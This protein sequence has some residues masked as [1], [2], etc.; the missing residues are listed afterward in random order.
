MK[1]SLIFSMALGLAFAAC[2]K[3]EVPIYD[4]DKSNFILF[5]NPEESYSVFSFS[6]HPEVEAGAA[7]E[8]AIPIEIMGMTK[9]YDREY[10]VSIVDTM[11][12]AKQGT[13]FT[14]PEKCVF[15]AG[16][17]DDTLF[18]KLYRV[19]DLKTTEVCLALRL[20]NSSDFI[21]G[22]PEYRTNIIYINDKISQPEWWNSSVNQYF[23]GYYSDKKYELLIK[24]TGVSDWTDLS[25]GERRVYALQL[26][27]YL[28]KEKAEGRT[29]Y[30]EPDETGYVE[31][32]TVKILG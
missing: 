7:Y 22:Q 9:D 31:E 3:E 27:R 29:V 28:A 25:D 13:H 18:V 30:E 5:T 12:T 15:R 32:M 1:K 23:L 17:F 16:Q 24:V 10:K 14:L 19:A 2:S 6:F 26:K 20:E 4:A 11:T 21:A 8:I